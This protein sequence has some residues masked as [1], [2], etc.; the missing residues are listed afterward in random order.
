MN[1][2]NIEIKNEVQKRGIERLCHFTPSRNLVHIIEDPRGILSSQ[3]L[4]LDENKVFNP[5]DSNRMD[6]YSNHVCCSIQYPNA[7]YFKSARARDSLFKDWVVL[8][9]NAHYLWV[10]GTKFS[11]GNA[12]FQ[13]GRFVEH[14]NRC[15]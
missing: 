15:F 8:M 11:Q 13:G 14:G 9:I 10:I 12:S 6:G 2:I 1:E 4:T 7:W 3:H 5:T